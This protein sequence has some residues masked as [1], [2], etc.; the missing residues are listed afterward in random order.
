MTHIPH[1]KSHIPDRKSHLADPKTRLRLARALWNWEPHTSQREFFLDEHPVKIAACGRRWGKSMAVA[2]DLASCAI[3]MPHSAQMVVSPTYD[4]SR[5]IFS[6]LKRFAQ[7]PA[8]DKACR[9]VHT[10]QPQ[11]AFGDSEILIRTAGDDGRNLRGHGVARIVVDEA[12]F[13]RAEIISSVLMPM[14]ADSGRRMIMISTPFGRNYFYKASLQG[15]GNASERNERFASFN[16]PSSLNPYISADYI[17]AQ[18]KELPEPQFR[19]EYMAEFIDDSASVFSWEAIRACAVAE[20]E[21]PDP[22]RI[23]VMGCD[24]AKYSDYTVCAVLDTTAEPGRVV[25]FERWN[26][27]DWVAQVERITDLFRRYRCHRVLVDA[28]GV[29]D[30]VFDALRAA[31]VWAEG[32]KFTNESKGRLVENL[33]MAISTRSVAYPPIQE[34][35]DELT[36]FEYDL[37]PSGNVVF[38]GRS[39]VHDDC[40]M[41]LGLALWA[42]RPRARSG[43]VMHSVMRQPLTVRS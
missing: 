23:Y 7:S 26:R 29:G 42:A 34:L 38:G 43:L 11:I 14:L 30:P 3:A 20:F 2:V 39:R 19:S 4:Q 15:S 31:G 41:A 24:L 40:V 13:V 12:A 33:S 10:P 37:T 16:F 27:I 35:L 6:Y 17:E 1:P 22:E 36:Y 25:A 32:Y 5:I 18:R 21:P 28:T 9:I 8:L